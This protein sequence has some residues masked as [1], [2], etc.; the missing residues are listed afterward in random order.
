MS[1][2]PHISLIPTDTGLLDSARVVQIDRHR[3]LFFRASARQATRKG[4]KNWAK[5]TPK[6]K[7]ARIHDET[8]LGEAM[9]VPM[10]PVCFQ[11]MENFAAWIANKNQARYLAPKPA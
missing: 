5:L 2:E 9:G 7:Q 6:E 3:K 10:I 4:G 1:A 11:T 8:S